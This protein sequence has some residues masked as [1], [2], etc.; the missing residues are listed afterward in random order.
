M[1]YLRK[2][3]FTAKE[4]EVVGTKTQMFGSEYKLF[5]TPVSYRENYIAHY[6]SKEPWFQAIH[7]ESV[8]VRSGG[9]QESL[10]RP[11]KKDMVDCFGVSWKWV[12]DAGGAITPGGNPIFDDANEWKDKIQ[13]PDIDQWDWEG[14]SKTIPDDRFACNFTLLNGFWFER[15]ISLMDFE[16]A[17]MALVDPD[18][19]DAVKELFEELT[20]L[21]IQLVDKFCE[22]F[23]CIDFFTLH[24]DWGSQKNPFFSGTIAREMFLPYMKELVDHIH[25]KGRFVTLHSCGHVEDRVNIF[26]EAGLDGWQLQSMN[27]IRKLYD[28]VGD[29]IVLE[30]WPRDFDIQDEKAAAEAARDYVDTFCKPGKTT[31]LGYNCKDALKSDVFREELYEYS[32]KKYLE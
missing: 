11:Y 20:N 4:L 32:R 16:N 26:I 6:D 3:A 27:D 22:Y 21:G 18:Q 7:S 24:D 28:E 13:M 23:P 2:P 17:A 29:K 14:D 15:L 25:S 8:A 19:K 10:S 31:V 1:S 30:A 9:Y 12:E 5:N